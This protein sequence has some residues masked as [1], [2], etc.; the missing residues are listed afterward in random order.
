MDDSDTLSEGDTVWMVPASVEEDPAL[1]I[2]YSGEQ[3]TDEIMNQMK[4]F[5]DALP[6]E[7][8]QPGSALPN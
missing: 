2:V 8:E 6:R 4:M 5:L 3:M 1:I 7:E